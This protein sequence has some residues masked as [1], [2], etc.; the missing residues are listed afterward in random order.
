MTFCGTGPVSEPETK[1]VSSFIESKKDNIVCF[2]TMHSFGQL[3]LTPYGYTKNKS[4]NHEELVS[5]QQ[6]SLLTKASMGPLPSFPR[7][8]FSRFWL[9]P[10]FCSPRSSLFSFVCLLHLARRLL[11]RLQVKCCFTYIN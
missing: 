10:C 9:Q 6:Q 4:S 7:F 2:L 1:A 5:P 3:I 11:G 8:P